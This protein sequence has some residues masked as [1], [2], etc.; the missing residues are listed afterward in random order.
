MHQRLR[1]NFCFSL[2]SHF[3]L[4]LPH[5]KKDIF[6]FFSHLK[7]KINHQWLYIL[8]IFLACGLTKYKSLL[9]L[10]KSSFTGY[11]FWNGTFIYNGLYWN[12]SDIQQW[13]GGGLVKHSIELLVCSFVSVKCENSKVVNNF[14]ILNNLKYLKQL[15]WR[16]LH[17]KQI[18]QYDILLTWKCHF[19]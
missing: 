6:F 18:Q 7:K 9:L 4:P 13:G 8:N 16:C 5:Q 10:S 12:S 3:L 14:L 2:T 17:Y 11:S 1:V 19:N 15:M